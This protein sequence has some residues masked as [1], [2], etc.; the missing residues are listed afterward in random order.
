MKSGILKSKSIQTFNERQQ[1][2]IQSYAPMVIEKTGDGERQ[3]DIYSRLLKDRVIFLGTGINDAV[4]NAVVAQ[5]LFLDYED[6]KKKIDM[7][8]NSPGGVV[9]SGLAI[10]DTMNLIK[11]PVHTICVGQAASMGAVILSCGEK[12]NRKILPNARVMIHQPSG[13]A[14]GQASDIQIRAVEIEKIKKNLNQILANNTGQ[15]MGRVTKDTDRV[16]FMSASESVKYGIVDSI[17]EQK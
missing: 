1:K 7:Y 4:A 14:E 8:I 9:T 2:M 16:Y 12:G 15:K 11:A 13:G 3:Y 6:P 5:L 10:I 17:L